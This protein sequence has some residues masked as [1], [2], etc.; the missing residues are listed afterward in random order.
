[1]GTV[2]SILSAFLFA[3]VVGYFLHI[4][5]HSEKLRFLSR[6]HM[7][8]HLREYGPDAPLR[9]KVYRLATGGRVNLFGTGLEWLVP[10][11]IVLVIVLGFFNAVLR[12]PPLYQLLFIASAL[13]WSVLMFGYMHDAMHLEGFWMERNRLLRGWFRRARRLHDIH[14]RELADDGRMLKN[15]GICFFV[16]DRLFGSLS[17]RH[18]P[19]NQA[20][21]QAAKQ[22]YS[23]IFR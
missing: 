5:L 3:E 2:V 9:T 7:F 17:T 15:Y 22:R 13:A 19:F 12:T 6:R 16:L 4:V 11:G 1:M 20:G 21:F 14:H 8:H 10:I 18:K 23:Y